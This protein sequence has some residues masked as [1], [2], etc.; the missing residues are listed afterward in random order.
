MP[1]V[2]EASSLPGQIGPDPARAPEERVVIDRLARLGILT[3]SLGLV[4][5]GPD[6]LGVAVEAPFADVEIPAGEF[7]RG[8]GLDR[9]DG[10]HVAPDQEGRDDL[11]QGGHQHGHRH[12]HGEGD[13]EALP[14]AMPRRLG[15]PA[16][17][18]PRGS[19]GRGRSQRS[20]PGRLDDRFRQ[21]GWAAPPG[22]ENVVSEDQHPQD[23]QRS[24]DHP[25]PIHRQEAEHRFDEVGILQP[26]GLIEGAPHE[27]LGQAGAVDR[28]HVQQDTQGGQPEMHLGE[29]HAVQL[30]LVQAGQ[31]PVHH[32]EGEEP[33]P[34]EGPGMHMRDDPVGVVRQ[35]VDALHREHRALERGHAVGRHRHHEELEHR[36]LGHLPPGAPQ[37]QQPVDHAAPG[38]HP[39]HDRKEHAERRGP[40]RQ[41]RVVQMMRAGPDVEEHQGPEMQDREPIAEHRAVGGLR[42]EVV[43]Q[44]KKRRGQ[45]EGDRIVAVPPLHEGVLHAGVERVALEPP[46]RDREVVEDVQDGD[47]DDAGDVEPERDIQMPL[48][49]PGDGPEEV[50][51]KGHPD[52]GDRD[53]DRPFEL[54][55]LLGLGEPER[56][57]ERRGDDD[58]LPSPEVK[59]AETVTVHPRLQESLSRVVGPGEERVPR[60]GEDDR[61]GMERAEPAEREPG[62]VEVEGR[63]GELEGDQKPHQHPD[64]APDEGGKHEFSDNGIIVRK[65]IE[66]RIHEN[67]SRGPRPACT[68]AGEK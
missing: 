39:E 11:E 1:E 53:V 29:A 12:H 18:A 68:D 51:R 40:L 63:V 6:H 47:G 28:R 7:E 3:V 16:P 21:R 65:R 50:H 20:Q 67:S 8:I 24:A 25:E 37:G 15:E 49:P 27:T 46:R 42:Q 10:R 14:G 54:G 41:G 60:E 32:A 30:R 64:Q 45:E 57:G 31:E 9:R 17:Q 13:G 66:V 2:G 43:H 38:G 44:A 34:A 19:E 22:H 36:V 5:E 52:H 23:V 61:V 56:Q 26:P 35:G 59:G 55:V 4:P 58:Q 62:N 33:V 48:P